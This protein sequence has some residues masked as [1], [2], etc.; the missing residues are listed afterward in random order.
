MEIGMIKYASFIETKDQDPLTDPC[1]LGS[2]QE[3]LFDLP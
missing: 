1:A 3:G 2:H